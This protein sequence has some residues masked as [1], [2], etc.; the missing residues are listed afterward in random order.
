VSRL[1][2]STADDARQREAFTD[3]RVPVAV[4]GLGKMGLP[5]AAVYADVCGNVVGA[6]VD[7][8]VVETVNRGESHVEREPGLDDLVADVVGRGALRAVADP[9]AAA[10]DAA[11]H[12]VIVPTLLDADDHPDL[13]IVEGVV[14]DVAAGLDPGD[15]VILESTA[16]PRTSADVVEPTLATRSGLDASEFGVAFCP[17]RTASGRALRDIRGAYPKVV[18]GTDDE[19]TRVAELVYSH[20]TDNDVVPVADATTAEAVKVFEGLYRDVNIALANE[21]ATFAD[22]FG[23][24]VREAIRVANTQPFCEIHD[25]GPGVGGHC[26]P[27]YPEFVAGEFDADADLLRTARAV[28]DRMPAHTA[29]LA[30]RALDDQGI[31]PAEATVAVVG[32]TYRANVAE[33][34]NAPAVAVASHLGDRGARVLGVDPLVADWTDVPAEPVGVREV[35]DRAD[36]AVL[37]TAHDEFDRIDW[38]AFD[39]VVDGRDDL[40]A[41][42][43]PVYTLGDGNA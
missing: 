33:L 35:A 37:V 23:I 22:E 42:D 40:D 41:I 32:F 12:V 11:V 2:G 38:S 15:Q 3:G 26:I 18:G 34:R 10:E 13:S 21:L 4:Y 16:P 9:V 28:N 24:D 36:A 29:A 31:D 1:Y 43:A 5:L 39:A 27:V 30:E 25:P 8:S 7:E 17:E 6:D 20:V 19:A 14:A